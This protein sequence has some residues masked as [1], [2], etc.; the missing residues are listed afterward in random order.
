MGIKP[1]TPFNSPL[2]PGGTGNLEGLLNQINRSF[3]N[4]ERILKGENRGL[5]RTAC[6]DYERSGSCSYNIFG[7]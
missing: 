5:E 7:D 4:M 3:D 2:S 6:Y 1:D